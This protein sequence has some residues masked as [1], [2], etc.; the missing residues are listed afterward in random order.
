MPC[1]NPT[2]KLTGLPMPVPGPSGM[3]ALARAVRGSDAVVIHDAL[4]VTS[5]LAMVLAKVHRKRVILIQHIAGIPFTSR[6]LRLILKAANQIVTRP[7]LRAADVRV[8][9]SDTVRQELL[10]HKGPPS[11][12]LFNGV[13]HEI[14]RPSSW[15]EGRPRH[16][17]DDARGTRQVLFVGRYVEK[18]GLAVLRALAISRPDLTFILAGSGR[19]RPAEWA[20]P[21]VRDLGP[22]SSE[23]IA[24]LYRAADLLLLP[25]V[26]EGYPLVIQ[27]AMACGL[28]VICGSPSDRADPA[29]RRWI[30]GIEI[31]LSRPQESAQ[32]CSDAIDALSLSPDER[33]AMARYALRHYNWR[34]MAQKLLTLARSPAGVR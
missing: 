34:A 29:A 11:E 12:L 25:S 22:Q 13:D 14:F 15:P 2:E 10:G 7:M 1:I 30:R 23:A 8:F 18:K 16:H 21:N 19:I 9:I 6:F 27:E 33:E 5:I 28:P 4:Y 3:R 26:G 17:P 32:R 20:L 31:D 24:D